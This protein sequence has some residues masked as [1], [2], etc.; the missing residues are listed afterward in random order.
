MSWAAITAFLGSIIGLFAFVKYFLLMDIRVEENTF[1]TIYDLY[2]NNSRMFTIQEEMVKENEHPSVFDAIYFV[3]GLP[4]FRLNHVE[5]LLHAGWSGKESIT[6]ISCFRWS[7]KSLMKKI[8]AKVEVAQLNEIGVPVEIV[9]PHYTDKIGTIKH[10]SGM[11]PLIDERIWKDV[12]QD[13]VE[14]V[15]N[16]KGKKTGAIFY[17]PPGNG[18]TSF[19]KYLA[20]RYRVPIKIMVFS[21]EYS[22]LDIIRMFARIDKRCIVLFEDFDSHF[23]GRE[24]KIGKEAK[25]TFDSILNGL[26]GIYNSYESVA[27]FL[28]S[29]NLEDVDYALTK[30]PSRFKFVREFPNPSKDIIQQHLP[31]FVDDIPEN[32]LNLDQM[33]QLS[34]TIHL[35]NNPCIKTELDNLINYDK[36]NAITAANITVIPTTSI[37]ENTSMTGASSS[38]A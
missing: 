6:N 14:V 30:R 32:T 11:S 31:K 2:R 15:V 38:T 10:N 3:P 20:V 37:S 13:F 26:D 21:P 18:K 19:I 5:R 23:K 12:E 9:L 1:K 33:L 17:G 27:F 8:A 16:G 4:W 36:N 7:Y 29:N 25:F 28:T 24:C 35:T 22:N 34:R